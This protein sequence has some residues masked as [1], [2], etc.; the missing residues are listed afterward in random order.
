[1]TSP[2][3]G[4]HD[5]DASALSGEKL[6]A[7]T[8]MTWIPSWGASPVRSKQ[9]SRLKRLGR[10]LNHE[11]PWWVSQILVAVLVGLVV[12]GALLLSGKQ[13]DDRVRAREDEI[14]A[15]QALHAEQ[16]ENL[17]FVRDR[18]LKSGDPLP[19]ASLHLEGQDLHSLAL[20]GANFTGAHLDGALLVGANLTG[21]NLMDAYLS[22]ANLVGAD[23][24]G[25]YLSRADLS[26]AN[27]SFAYLSRANLIG[28]YLRGADLRADLRGAYLR[29][30]DL[31]GANL[32]NIYYDTST[33]WPA[34][35]P[36]PPSRPKP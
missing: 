7:V 10:R 2:Q 20:P 6:P 11:P 17:R 9:P 23:L 18:A 25:A 1:M 29:G 5:A 34:G 15:R 3:A 26:G 12:G 13:L 14:A 31:T 30:A 8:S 19:F 27:L 16:I 4:E 24:V 22:R 33:T 28:A 36:H 32:T 21:A 35:F